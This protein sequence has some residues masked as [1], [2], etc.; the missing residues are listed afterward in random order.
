MDNQC[1]RKWTSLLSSITHIKMIHQVNT[2]TSEE[3]THSLELLQILKENPQPSSS[4]QPR[5]KRTCVGCKATYHSRD[6]IRPSSD[7][8]P[9]FPYSTCLHC[10]AKRCNPDE[11]TIV[12]LKKE[13]GFLQSTPDY[14][15]CII[16]KYNEIMYN[17]YHHAMFPLKDLHQYPT[18]T[19][20]YIYDIVSFTIS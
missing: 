1:P 18:D 9:Y 20:V 12:Q 6:V 10:L 5:T 3:F 8:L 16:A 2:L 14:V 13:F 7:M 11:E 4:S 17:I 19:E 15:Q